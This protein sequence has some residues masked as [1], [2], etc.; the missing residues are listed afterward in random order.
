MKNYGHIIA[1]LLLI[2]LFSLLFSMAGVMLKEVPEANA[3]KQHE[4]SLSMSTATFFD[5]IDRWFELTS[6][7]LY[8]AVKPLSNSVITIYSIMFAI[9]L[10]L[11]LDLTA[12]VGRSR[13]EERMERRKSQI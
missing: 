6:D 5:R 10:V 8:Y 3:I 12:G 2:T 13:T 11:L 7:K 1:K 9:I 4:K